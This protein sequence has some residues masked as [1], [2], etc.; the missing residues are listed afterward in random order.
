MTRGHNFRTKTQKDKSIVTYYYL[1]IY[2]GWVY[3]WKKESEIEHLYMVPHDYRTNGER[4][5]VASH[6]GSL[7]AIAK[8]SRIIC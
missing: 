5:V 4:N 3:E 8:I 7:I 2:Y 6:D 1:D